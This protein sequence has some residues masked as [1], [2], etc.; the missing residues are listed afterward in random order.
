MKTDP[1]RSVPALEDAPANGRPINHEAAVLD[2]YSAGALRPSA[3]LCCPTRYDPKFLQLIPEEILDRDYGCGDP[4]AFVA[5][6]ESVLD[7]GSGAGKICYILS[8]KVGSTARVIG[9]D[10]ND[11]MLELADRHRSE[12]AARLGWDNMEFRK[13]RIQDLK[14]DL[15]AAE[16]WMARHP[17][18]DLSALTAF[19]EFQSQQREDNPLIPDEAVDVVVSNCVLNLVRPAEKQA[20]FSEIFRVLKVGGRAV[21]SDIVSDEDVPDSMQNDP[22]LWTGCISGALREDRF[23]AAFE[24]AGFHGVEVLEWEEEPW[25]TVDGIEFRSMSVTASKGKQG[26]CLEKNQAV[27]YKGPFSEVKD[28]DG[29]CFPRGRRIAVCEKTFELLKHSPYAGAMIFIQPRVAVTEPKEFSCS[30]VPHRHPR[31]TKG[32]QF[33]LTTEDPGACC[34]PGESC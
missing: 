31:E 20:L 3:E 19:E 25:R 32:L 7:L 17:I 29:H 34:S 16:R 10:M 21:I 5:E 23:L 24:H 9:V 14:T 8:Q 1:V 18:H 26:V 15:R 13:G 4:S 6:G 30:G 22:D 33:D 12:F 28:D 27:I 2:R 11:A